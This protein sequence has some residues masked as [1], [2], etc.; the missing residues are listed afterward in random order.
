MKTL[1]LLPA[2]D[3]VDGRAVQ[4][5]QGIAGSE[6]TFGDPLAA[7]L[8]W[9]EAGA[10]WLHLVDLDAAFGRGNNAETI[11]RIVQEC[12]LR[13]EL[14]GGIRD[15]TSLD[16]A[17]ATGCDRVNIGTAALERPEWCAEVLA[18]HGERIAIALDVRGDRLATRGW[19]AEAGSWEPV[20]ERLV[21]EGCE[22]FVVTDVT[23]DGTLSGPNYEL[24]AEVARLSGK[25]VVASGGIASLDHLRALRD[26]VDSGIEGAIVGTAL[27]VGEIDIREALEICG[28]TDG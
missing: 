15:D 14:T 24:L 2:V 9:A 23:Q 17:L 5:V 11:A 21:S 12:G 26:R 10:R 25:K 1:E 8:R 28:V 3:V 13:V 7:A 20:V 16:R 4:L 22:R 27:Y 19:T 6:K 18:K